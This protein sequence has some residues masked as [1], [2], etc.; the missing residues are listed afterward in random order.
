MCTKVRHIVGAPIILMVRKHVHTLTVCS[1]FGQ[2]FLCREPGTSGSAAVPTVILQT[3][4]MR[5]DQCLTCFPMNP[6]E[7][8]LQGLTLFRK[9][10]FSGFTSTDLCWALDMEVGGLSRAF[11]SGSCSGGLAV[12]AQYMIKLLYLLAYEICRNLPDSPTLLQG[13]FVV[14]ETKTEY[15]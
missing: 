8:S 14:A 2:V 7:S 15:F 1:L 10:T 12:T 11:S 13:V 3:A 9:W 5:G 6:T 4:L